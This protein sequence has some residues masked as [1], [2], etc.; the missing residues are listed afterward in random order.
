MYQRIR[1]GSAGAKGSADAVVVAVFDGDRK[2]PRGYGALD[3]SLGGAV[4]DALKRAEVSLEAGALNAVPIK[5]GAKG[6]SVGARVFV[7]GLGDRERFTDQVLRVGAAKVSKAAWAA[8]AGRIRIEVTGG[9]DGATGAAEAGQAIGD[10]LAIGNFEFD[11]FRGAGTKPGGD[12]DSKPRALV[13][14]GEVAVR[15]GLSLGLKVG[16][17]VALAR[18]LAATPPNVANPGYLV[19][20]C[21]KMARQTGLKCRVIDKKKAEQLGMRGLLA[22][23]AAGSRPPALIE[24][25]HKPAGAKGRPIMLVGKAVT[26]DTGGYSMKSPAGMDGMKYD[27]CGGMAVI[28]AMHAI[29]RLGLAMH[30][31]GLVPTAENMVDQTAYRPG[32]ILKMYNGVTVEVTNTD[33]EGRLILADA[34]AYGCKRY[35]PRAVIDLATLTGGVVV[36]LGSQCAGVFCEDGALRERLY[37]A[38]DRTGELLWRLPLWREHKELL[39]GTHSDIV[40]SGGREAHPIQG[41]AFL[42]YFLDAKDAAGLPRVPWAHI[43]IAGVADVKDGHALYAKGPTGFGVRLLVDAVAKWSK[44]G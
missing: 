23:G 4:S 9:L 15:K 29:A 21:R 38:A 42:S 37:R 10:G 2:L 41:A 31:I 43:D 5:E 39:K 28:G 14:R 26:F 8:R 20:E 40:N 19:S 30:V 34:L 12:G 36:A 7:L 18:E 11:R 6:A 33:A 35:Q 13:V 3:R 25:E 27:K 44:R 1:L 17:S 16:E 24:L 32:D 22:V